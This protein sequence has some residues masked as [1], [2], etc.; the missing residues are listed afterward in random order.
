M[1]SSLS[2][3]TFKEGGITVADYKVSCEDGGDGAAKWGFAGE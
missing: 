2:V 1:G 3:G